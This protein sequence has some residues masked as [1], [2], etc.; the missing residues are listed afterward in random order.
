MINGVDYS[1]SYVLANYIRGNGN[2]IATSLEKIGSG[3]RVRSP[4]DDAGAFF[5]ASTLERRKNT[6][7][8]VANELSDNIAGL[9]SGLDA[10]T[11]IKSKLEDLKDISNRAANSDD[12]DYTLRS[13]LATEYE[14]IVSDINTIVN[15][16]SF[17]GENLLK[18]S[19]GGADGLMSYTVTI[20]EEAGDTYTYKLW[21]TSFTDVNGLN[22][23][24]DATHNYSDPDGSVLADKGF[25]GVAPVG[26][27]GATEK[28]NATEFYNALNGTNNDNEGS[29]LVQI[30]RNIQRMSSVISMLEG[31]QNT[32]INKAA[33]YESAREALVGVNEATEATTLSALQMKQQAGAYFLAQANTQN[34]NVAKLIMGMG[35]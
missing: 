35:G 20:D 16:F 5:I 32:L 14:N 23:G 4:A 17:N 29:G 27:D 12:A 1:A 15:E 26:T 7:M 34:S 21:E 10:L 9:K 30:D 24:A 13:S 18:D 8:S 3:L 19:D 2:K 11:E 25:A 28:A 33:N 22:L 31:R 6:T